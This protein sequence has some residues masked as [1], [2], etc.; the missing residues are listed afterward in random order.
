MEKKKN[1]T[2]A[3]RKPLKKRWLRLFFMIIS[4]GILVGLDQWTK[5][6]VVRHMVPYETEIRIFGNAFVL[7][8]I[9]NA[10]SAWGMFQGKQ[11]FLLLVTAVALFLIFYVYLHAMRTGFFP[12]RLC[13]TFLLAGALGNMIDRIR[14]HYVV[15]F[16]YIKLIDFPV[17]NVA[18]IYVTGS[19]F[20]LILLMIFHYSSGDLDLLTGERKHTQK[21]G[22][23]L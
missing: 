7:R 2:A 23:S 1:K 12:V 21:N 16:F 8:Y 13:L 5:A 4:A 20:A 19:L 6:L 22:E 18:D 17:F 14:L 10:G 11:I 9:R 15:D 3:E